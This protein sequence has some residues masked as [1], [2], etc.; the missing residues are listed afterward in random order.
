MEEEVFG[1][2]GPHLRGNIG[3]ENPFSS[4]RILYLFQKAFQSRG[5]ARTMGRGEVRD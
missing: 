5:V 3:K 1:E 4:K 2:V